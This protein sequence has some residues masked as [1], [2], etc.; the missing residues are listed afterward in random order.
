MAT[1]TPTYAEQITTVLEAGY[2][3]GSVKRMVEWIGQDAERVA[4]LMQVFTSGPYRICQRASWVVGHLGQRHPHLMMP[5]LPVLI[6]HLARTD[7]HDAIRRNSARVLEEIKVPDE[8]L[9]AAADACFN[10]VADPNCAVAI[11][12]FALTT[13]NDICQREPA[14]WPEL[15]LIV[16]EQLPIAKPAFLVRAKRLKPPL[17]CEAIDF[18]TI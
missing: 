2:T 12:A 3:L 10:A 14:L 1:S 15:K 18:S 5:W 17:G 9:G 13:L 16:E 8:L 4:A 7:I 11:R 6:E